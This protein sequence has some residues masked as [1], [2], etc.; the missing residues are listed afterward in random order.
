MMTCPQTGLPG[1]RPRR[2]T[3]CGDMK[4]A[5]RAGRGAGAAGREPRHADVRPRRHDDRAASPSIPAQLGRTSGRPLAPNPDMRPPGHPVSRRDHDP[6]ASLHKHLRLHP[7]PVSVPLIPH[8]RQPLTCL[9]SPRTLL[10]ASRAPSRATGVPAHESDSRRPRVNEYLHRDSCTCTP[11]TRLSAMLTERLCRNGRCTEWRCRRCD[12]Y[13]GG[14]GPAGCGCDLP[15][16]VAAG[17]GVAVLA[18]AD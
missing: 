5:R 1:Q 3:T 4:G 14:V 17:A 12:G 11:R 10:T 16:D 15:P 6:R 7:Q 9:P 8:R 18:E 2:A 13:L